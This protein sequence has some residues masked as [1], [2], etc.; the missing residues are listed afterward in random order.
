MQF[1]IVAVAISAACMTAQVAQA[2]KYTIA[3]F[4]EPS[5][6][7]TRFQH[8]EFADNVREASNGEIDFE[9]LTGGMLMPAGGTLEGVASGVAHVSILPPSYAP[10]ALPVANAIGDMGWLNPDPLLLAFAYADFNFNEEIASA[11]W[12]KNGVLYGAGHATPIY[13]YMCGADLATLDDLKGKK[14]RQAGSSYVRFG[15]AIGVT[16]VQL[17][18]SEIYTALE[19]G[20]IDCACGD[21]THLQS[22]ATIGE[23][24]NSI[25]MIDLS[26][27]FT[28]A[29]LMYNREFWQGLSGDQRRLLLDEGARS[30]VRL[31]M[32]YLQESQENLDW[33]QKNGISV[34]QPDAALTQALT[35]FVDGGVGDMVG[36]AKTQFNI[37]DPQA[38]FDNFDGYITK[39]EDLM[40]DVDRNDE[41]ALLSLVK[42][43]IF[44]KVDVETYGID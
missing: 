14:M 26:P 12:K 35:D 39:W 8:V 37:E 33:A 30:M 2:E 9:V 44:D 5:H 19:R 34:H 18:A 16:A 27:Y 40:A 24:V 1:H 25:I 38:L 28:S 13:H 29:G 32:A 4:V 11:E 6:P 43:N 17:P 20:V 3:T 36:Y 41:A 10:S 22:G 21:L 23:L 31:T 7:I 15:D 42:T